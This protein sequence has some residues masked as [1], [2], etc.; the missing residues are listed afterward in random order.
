MIEKKIRKTFAAT[1]LLSAAAGLVILG[2][3]S[4]AIIFW[5]TH[6]QQKER[7]AAINKFL[8]F[9]YQTEELFNSNTFLLTG[10]LSL[11]KSF[12]ETLPKATQHEMIRKIT[13]R[14]EYFL[15]INFSTFKILSANITDT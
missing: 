12:P 3:S 11:I 14:Y 4:L 1:I 15:F 13:I 7:I 8:N 10:Y 6:E 9:R 2:T 5:F